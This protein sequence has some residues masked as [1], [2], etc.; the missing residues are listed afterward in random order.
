MFPGKLV[1]QRYKVSEELKKVSILKQLVL[2]TNRLFCHPVFLILIVKS[3]TSLN[4]GAY[5]TAG[6]FLSSDE[7]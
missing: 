3:I 4:D 1:F 6:F 7:K 2:P 5:G